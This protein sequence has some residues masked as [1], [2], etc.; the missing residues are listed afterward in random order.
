MY[1]TIWR[2]SKLNGSMIRS[3]VRKLKGNETGGLQTQVLWYFLQNYTT[4][5]TACGQGVKGNMEKKAQPSKT[6]KGHKQGKA[7][8]SLLP[9]NHLN[10]NKRSNLDIPDEG[11]C[12]KKPKETRGM[13]RSLGQKNPSDNS[14]ESKILKDF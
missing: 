14:P 12:M 1:C 6:Q 8:F 9:Y 7:L 13:S 11:K 5:W 4:E 3:H 2:R 10:I